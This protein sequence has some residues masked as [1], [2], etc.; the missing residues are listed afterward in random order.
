MKDYVLELAASKNG[1]NDKF[2]IIREYLQ[3]YILR[4]MQDFGAFHYCAF[5]GGT[6]LRFLYDLPRFSEDLD[7]SLVN[8][9]EKTFVELIAHIKKELELS[10]YNVEISYKDNKTVQSA[11]IKFSN[12][13]YEAGLSGLKGQKISV[14][15]EIDTNPP[16]GA[17]FSTKIVNKYFPLAFLAY[18]LPFLFAGKMHAVLTRRYSKGRDFYDI[19]WYLSRKKDMKPNIPFLTNALKQ[20]GWD[21]AMPGEDTWRDY[22]KKIVEGVNWDTINKDVGSFLEHPADMNVFTKE[23]LLK[24]IS[25]E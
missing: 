21:K 12:L 10:G 17:E 22:L 19:F 4:I 11:M 9:Q 1:I 2:N 24:V 13:M 8:K 20:T 3:S 7:F 5:L 16:Q 23:N 6:A 18:D 14:K 25:Q 15:L